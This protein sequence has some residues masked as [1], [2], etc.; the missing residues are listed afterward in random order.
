MQQ[1]TS[2]VTFVIFGLFDFQNEAARK[3][4]HAPFL[5][6]SIFCLQVTIHP[7]YTSGDV[8]GKE[9]QA[10]NHVRKIV[11][12]FYKDEEKRESGATSVEGNDASSGKIIF[13]LRWFI[14]H[15]L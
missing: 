10:L 9:G 7:P 14:V 8:R 2:Q 13:Q 11:D 12:K 1:V 6:L 4:T 5:N 15:A 3:K